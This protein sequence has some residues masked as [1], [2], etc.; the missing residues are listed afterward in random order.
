MIDKTREGGRKTDRGKGTEEKRVCVRVRVRE[1][2]SGEWR[3]NRDC[4]SF[5]EERKVGR[6][7]VCVC[8]CVCITGEKSGKTV[9]VCVC[10]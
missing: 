8:V 9:C 10:V 4:V 2:E 3:G 5:S 1:K 6:Q 7:C